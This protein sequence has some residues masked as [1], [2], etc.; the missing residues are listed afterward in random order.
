M[1]QL[2]PSAEQASAEDRIDVVAP[3]G[4]RLAVYEW[5]NV[6]GPEVLLVH[7]FAQCHLCFEPQYRS[8]LAERFRLVA[9]DM[10]GHGGSGQPRDSAAYQGGR[11]WAD[12]LA[13][14]MAAKGLKR[15][16]LVGWSMGGRVD[17][18]VPDQLRRRRD[19]RRQLRRLARDRGAT[20][21]G[22]RLAQAPARPA[23][24]R[25][26]DRRRDRLFGRLLRQEA[27]RGA[28]PPRARLQRASTRCRAPGDRR[29]VNR[30]ATD[31]RR[32]ASSVTRAGPDHART[33]GHCRAAGRGGDG[34]KHHRACMS[35]MVRRLRAFA[36]RRGRNAL[37]RRT[38]G[39]RG[40]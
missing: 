31:D 30:S 37:Q 3:D 14:V 6:G 10:R 12:D 32:F 39:L 4:T 29:L 34:R 19:R 1:T 8:A 22:T 5:G 36:V 21:P 20:L 15:P 18:A 7:G 13:T 38:R 16:V 9:Y 26:R 17:P 35:V 40:G 25:G 24:A 11:V 27:E 2:A 23:D 28:V 33:P